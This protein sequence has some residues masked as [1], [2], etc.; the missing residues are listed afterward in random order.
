M[1]LVKSVIVGDL[2]IVPKTL[3]EEKTLVLSLK[4]HV[5]DVAAVANAAEV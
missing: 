5:E 2:K 4:R 3:Y 1:G